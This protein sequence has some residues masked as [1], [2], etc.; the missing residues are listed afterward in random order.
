M[1]KPDEKKNKKL[2]LSSSWNRFVTLDS[3]VLNAVRSA[4]M[5]QAREVRS[6]RPAENE[7][8][9]QAALGSYKWHITLRNIGY[10]LGVSAIFSAL[11]S[12]AFEVAS[13]SKDSATF[14]MALKAPVPYL[15]LFAIFAA[16]SGVG[17]YLIV[18][19]V[20]PATTFSR[21]VRELE[22]V[23]RADTNGLNRASTTLIMQV[24]GKAA[25]A[26]FRLLTQRTINVGVRPDFADEIAR[27]SESILL[28]T[29]TGPGA[30]YR[31]QEAEIDE[32]V[33]FL[34]EVVALVVLDRMDLLPYLR[35]AKRMKMLLATDATESRALRE[36]LQPFH[37]DTSLRVLRQDVL[38]LLTLAIALAAL[39]VSF[40]KP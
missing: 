37:G 4:D 32:Y 19:R 12:L 22:R 40:A 10:H 16:I 33:R 15:M 6:V 8:A 1:K 29:P 23:S 25:R 34:R 28:A 13:T 7:A 9:L 20:D 18:A 35:T 14:K 24:S 39:I 31:G 36:Y 2:R 27:I 5:K 38:P 17:L 11:L 21:H 30:S 26:L 3:R